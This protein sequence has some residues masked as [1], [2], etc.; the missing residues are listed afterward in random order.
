MAR[1][2]R[3]NTGN[4]ETRLTGSGDVISDWVVGLNYFQHDKNR[5]LST[6]AGPGSFADFVSAPEQ[7]FDAEDVA[8]FW[9]V[10]L[11]AQ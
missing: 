6:L 7:R 1:L 3:M 5:Q 2:L 10:S 11:S 8:L 4:F 9:S